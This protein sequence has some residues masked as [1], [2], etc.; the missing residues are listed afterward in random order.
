MRIGSEGHT[1]AVVVAGPARRPLAQNA[2]LPPTKRHDPVPSPLHGHKHAGAGAARP[3]H[4][5]SQ[6]GDRGTTS[7]QGPVGG[8]GGKVGRAELGSVRELRLTAYS[9]ARPHRSHDVLPHCEGKSATAKAASP[10]EFAEIQLE[11]NR[12][13]SMPCQCGT[14]V[15]YLG[16]IRQPCEVRRCDS[17]PVRKLCPAERTKRSGAIPRPATGQFYLTS[18]PTERQLTAEDLV[19]AALLDRVQ[20]VGVTVGETQ[21]FAYQVQVARLG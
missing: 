21:R 9:R 10:V 13:I 19:L 5:P 2:D 7:Q 17:E 4:L 8:V 12:Q 16:R 15:A 11:R 18:D 1:L 14:T 6:I 3:S 20:S